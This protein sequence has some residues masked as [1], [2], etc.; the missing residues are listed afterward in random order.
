[1]Q[2]SDEAAAFLRESIISGELPSGAFIRPDRIAEALESS[3]TPVREALVT[4]R[5]EGFVDLSPRKGFTV[6]QISGK[7]IRDLFAAQAL[8]AGELAARAVE[9]CTEEQLI[10][11]KSVQADLDRAL[12]DNE[13]AEVERLNHEFH[14]SITRCAD[15]ARMAWLLGIG[16]RYV[17]RRFFAMIAGWPQASVN[18][19]VAIIDALNRHDPDSA[20]AAMAVHFIHAGELLA[21]HLDSRPAAGADSDEAMDGLADTAGRRRRSRAGHAV[22]PGGPIEWP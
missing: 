2:L 5:G 9:R 4:L 20:R 1:M 13:L 21:D 19:H 16:A 22:I 10:A 12:H 15:S 7:D 14:R 6:A 17:P 8:L 18:D 11:I 3:V